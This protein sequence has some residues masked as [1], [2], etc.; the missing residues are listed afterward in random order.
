MGKDESEERLLAVDEALEA[1]SQE[2]PE[3]AQLVKLRFFVGFSHRE[4]A[5]VLGL[6]HATADRTW[7]FAKAWLARTLKKT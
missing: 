5:E 7:L 2:D 3:A 1:L 6:S 4:A